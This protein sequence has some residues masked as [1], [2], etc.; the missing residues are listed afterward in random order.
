MYVSWPTPLS[1][2][3]DV[4]NGVTPGD[5]TLHVPEG[6]EAAYGAA[7]TWK[8]FR[9]AGD[10][11]PLGAASLEAQK[12]WLHNGVLYVDTPKSE[13]IEVYALNGQLLYSVRK[14]EGQAAFDLNSLPGGVLIVRGESGW[15][16]K[17]MK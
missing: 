10:V 7:D 13:R 17:I 6:T 11:P 14:T 4:F 5:I 9:I 2:T 15:T 8:E 3:A 12:V 1:I 16:E